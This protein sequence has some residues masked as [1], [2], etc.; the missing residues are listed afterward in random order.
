[1]KLMVRAMSAPAMKSGRIP[2]AGRGAWEW[3]ELTV[4]RA[5]ASLRA[6]QEDAA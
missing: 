3:A 2:I 5:D 6:F 4:A 1:L